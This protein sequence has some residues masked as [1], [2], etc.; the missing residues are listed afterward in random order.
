MWSR[1]GN[2]GLLL[3][4]LIVITEPAYEKLDLLSEFT[5]NTFSV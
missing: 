2:R 3:T 5:V 4:T 1:Q